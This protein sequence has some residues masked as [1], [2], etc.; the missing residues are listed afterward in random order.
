[1]VSELTLI[2]EE[3]KAFEKALAIYSDKEMTEERWHNIVAAIGGGKTLEEVRK[4]YEKSLW[5]I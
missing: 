1:M 3:N 5:R 4:H 2:G